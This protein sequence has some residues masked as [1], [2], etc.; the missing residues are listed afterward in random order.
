MSHG[1]WLWMILTP[2]PIERAA[3]SISG[4]A[5][6]TV[7]VQRTVEALPAPGRKWTN[8]RCGDVARR[9]ST[10]HNKN[11][12]TRVL[13]LS[14]QSTAFNCGFNRWMQ[15]TRRYRSGRSVADEAE[16]A[17]LLFGKPEGSHMGPLTEGRDSSPDRRLFDLY[18]SS[19]QRIVAGDRRDTPSRAAPIEM[20]AGRDRA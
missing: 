7:V 13:R 3:I 17:H 20:G 15:H 12:K 1:P 5:G 10:I 18:H 4:I 11:T 14:R 16:A 19:I 8:G 2:A 6:L 9:I